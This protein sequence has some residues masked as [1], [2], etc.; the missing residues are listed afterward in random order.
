MSANKTIP[1]GFLKSAFLAA[2]PAILIVTGSV[3]FKGI[4]LLLGYPVSPTSMEIMGY[5]GSALAAGLMIG[6]MSCWVRHGPTHL[7]GPEEVK[8][9]IFSDDAPRAIPDLTK[10]PP[11]EVDNKAKVETCSALA[12]YVAGFSAAFAGAVL[13]S[14][15]GTAMLLMAFAA[16][17]GTAA[18]AASPEAEQSATIRGLLTGSVLSAA[19]MLGIS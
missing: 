12:N 9:R 18:V 14:H 1:K 5:G 7:V 3:V 6:A 19:T 4:D 2:A 11:P 8:D 13:P 17:A 16:V 10:L 15:P